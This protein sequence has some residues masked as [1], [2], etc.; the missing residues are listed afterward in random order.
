MKIAVLSDIHGNRIGLE[1]AL[2]DIQSR[3]HID[4]YWLLGDYCLGGGDPIGVLKVLSDLTHTRFIRGNTDRYIVEPDLPLE[5]HIQLTESLD[6]LLVHSSP[7]RDDGSGF[8]PDHDDVTVSQT[9]A[10]AKSKLICVGHTHR[11]HHR[12]IGH[13]HIINPGSIGKPVTSDK[14][15]SYIILDI[16]DGG[17]TIQ[18]Y[19]VEYDIKSVIQQMW[20]TGYP[21]TDSM[22]K[23]YLE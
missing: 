21:G 22:K 16:T 14:R 1:A 19:A 8:H 10:D 15:A 11:Q 20:D 2:N 23:F 17:Y 9:F 7:G 12:R 5:I 3:G 18:S 13:K 6:V 4:E